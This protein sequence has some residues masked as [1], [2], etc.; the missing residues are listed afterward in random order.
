MAEIKYKILFYKDRP[1][2]TR[3]Y[4]D[5]MSAEGFM[6][7]DS[8]WLASFWTVKGARKFVDRQ[9]KK[10]DFKVIEDAVLQH[11]EQ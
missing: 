4:D 10:R 8:V 5:K 1:W 6:V 2:Y 7:P 9:A 3:Q 11:K